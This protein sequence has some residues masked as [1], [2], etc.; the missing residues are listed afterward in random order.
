MTAPVLQ[1]AA[2]QLVPQ[3]ATNFC[4]VW[5]KTPS[6]IRAWCQKG[7]IPTAFKHPSGEWW[8]VPAHPDFLGFDLTQ[9]ESQSEASTKPKKGKKDL[10][11]KLSHPH[12]RIAE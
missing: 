5:N 3:P 9:V 11:A 1:I 8:V 6:A 2:H 10:S 12:L 4:S 7:W